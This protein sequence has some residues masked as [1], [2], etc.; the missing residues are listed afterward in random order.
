MNDK[1]RFLKS[2]RS[3]LVIL[4][5][6]S[7][8]LTVYFMPAHRQEKYTFTVG[9]PWTYDVLIAPFNF[10]IQKNR[11]LLLSFSNNQLT[12]TS[13]DGFTFGA[14][15]RFKDISFDVKFAEKVHKLKSDL[16]VQLNLTYNSNMVVIRKINQNL[17]QISS[18][19]SVWMAE[20]SAE[21]AL[22]QNLTAKAF[23]QTNI[24]TPY[25][26]NA[27]PNSTTKGGLSIRF[28]F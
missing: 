22:T 3:L 5:V 11:T 2:N 7:A 17:S 23:F 8:L 15:Y 27:Y 13:R 19:S 1:R 20:L 21:Y 12:E 14:G 28:S 24:N 10:S 9:K 4:S 26:S 18:G 16:V 25:I 6:V